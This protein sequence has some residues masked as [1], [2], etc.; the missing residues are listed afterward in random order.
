MQ[1]NNAC[2]A[3]FPK[4]N[5]YRNRGVDDYYHHDE[6]EEQDNHPI[7]TA[8]SSEA[9]PKA[10]IIDNGNNNTNDENNCNNP[11]VRNRARYKAIHVPM[12]VAAALVDGEVPA[13]VDFIRRQPGG[14]FLPG[15]LK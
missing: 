15:A 10:T 2:K 11:N 14:R 7:I 13:L 4:A 3:A 8:T 1:T 9:S 5:P 12:E 6:D